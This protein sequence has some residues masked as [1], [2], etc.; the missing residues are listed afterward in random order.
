MYSY[1][2][3]CKE[4]SLIWKLNK[5]FSVCLWEG[6]GVRTVSILQRCLKLISCST[7]QSSRR[8]PPPGCALG[9]AQTHQ[10]KYG[11]LPPGRTRAAPTYDTWRCR[12]IWGPWSAPGG[13]SRR[14]GWG[15]SPRSRQT[16]TNSQS[17]NAYG[18]S[19]C[20]QQVPKWRF[21]YIFIK[22]IFSAGIFFFCIF[23]YFLVVN[24]LRLFKTKILFL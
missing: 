10:G 16:Q 13:W 7:R 23:H 9:T 24:I 17:L 18:A 8:A 6:G 12:A 21:Q 14:W 15:L 3:Y 20:P 2:H 1:L 4:A 22:S 5:N 11:R 19:Q